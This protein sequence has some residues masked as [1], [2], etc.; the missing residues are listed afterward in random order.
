MTTDQFKN[1]VLHLAGYLAMLG[2]FT[3]RGEFATAAAVLNAL[4]ANDAELALLAQGVTTA[5]HALAKLIDWLRGGGHP[6]A[7]QA[8]AAI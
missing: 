4:A 7:A 2:E 8:L 5:G 6:A 3:G 1:I